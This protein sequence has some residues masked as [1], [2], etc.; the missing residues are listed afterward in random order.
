MNFRVEVPLWHKLKDGT[1]REIPIDKGP[2]PR[3]SGNATKSP[4]AKTDHA[5]E[6]ADKETIKKESYVK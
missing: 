1:A 3:S 2:S 5:E 4:D 6:N